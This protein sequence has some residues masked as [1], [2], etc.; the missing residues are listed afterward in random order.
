[1]LIRAVAAIAV[2]CFAT[3]AVADPQRAPA[4][5]FV[6]ADIFNLEYADSPQ[7]SPDGRTVAY[8]RVSA[9]IMTDHF[10]HSIWLVESEGRSNRPLIQGA[11]NYGSPVWSPNGRAIAYVAGEPAGDELRVFYLDTQRSATIARLA[12]GASN[13]TWSPDGKTLAF[14]GFVEESN[15]QPAGMP[16]KPEGAQWAEPA[17]VIEGV[18]Y[19]IDGAGYL[20]SGFEQIFVVPAEG[21][22]PRQLTYQDRNHDGRLSWSSDGRRLVFSANAEEGWEYRAVESD[23]Y[24]L[25]IADGTITRLTNRHGPEDSPVLSPDGRHLAYVGFDDRQQFY[26]V[27]DLYVANADGTGARNITAHF[28][29]DVQDPQWAGNGSIY[30]L[31]ADHGVTKLGRIGASGGNVSTVLSNVGGTDVGRPYTG[32]A[33]SVNASGA[34]AATTTTP[35]QPSDVSVSGG[36]RITHL[37]DDIFAGKTIPTAEHIV[38]PSSVDQRPI[39]AWIVRPPNFDATKKYPLLL[40]I[41]GGPVAAYGPSFAAE[42]QLYA[43]AGYIVVYANPR[44]SDSYGGEFGNLIN[45]DYPDKDYDDLMSVVDAT[46][47]REPIDPHRLFVTGGSGGGVLTAWIVGSTNRFAAAVVQKPVINWASFVLTSDFTPLYAQYWLGEFP[48]EQGA[49]DR[50]WARSPLSRVGNVTTPT[51]LITGEA[52]MRTPSGEAEQF[53][54]ALRLRHVETRLIRVPGASHDIASRPSGMII[55][56]V[57]TLQWFSEHGGEPVPDGATGLPALAGEV[58]H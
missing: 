15:P 36:R 19:R 24:A 3:A 46:I 17:R 32:G 9:D 33:F 44:G 31:F 27:A 14:E 49:I 11:G 1:M 53:Y 43:A 29:R 18:V 7:I 35:T 21:G 8:V 39:D 10:R 26:Q 23:V 50:Y 47:A 22:T 28:D 13:L 5:H 30:F 37:N 40:E 54:E 20:H 58:Q 52:D 57:N 42:I 45:R 25:T 2:L 51:A 48:W 16:P 56:V 38:V 34:Y 55:K 6:A 12:G 4:T 41:H